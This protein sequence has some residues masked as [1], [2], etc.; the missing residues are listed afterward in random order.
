MKRSAGLKIVGLLVALAA[1]LGMIQGM[2]GYLIAQLSQFETRAPEV[3][4]PAETPVIHR[5]TLRLETMEYNTLQIGTFTDITAGQHI[6]DE[7]ATEGYRVFVTSEE[8]YHLWIGCFSSSDG[9][10]TIPEAIKVKGEDI[11]VTKA[12]LNEK[13]LSFAEDQLFIKDAIVPLLEKSDVVLKHSLKMFQT[14]YYAAYDDALWQQQIERL[15]EEIKDVHSFTE[16]VL[17]E[18]DKQQLAKPLADYQVLLEEYSQSLTIVLDKKSD[19]AVLLAQSYLLE[20]I[21]QYHQLIDTA[22]DFSA[23]L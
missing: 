21:S 6:I 1:V 22:N 10:A 12:L 8:P 4:S 16:E 2:G 19:Q 13:V 7:L 9:M 15:R 17:L 3:D 23:G 14:A 5:Q 18:A 11:Y 20:L